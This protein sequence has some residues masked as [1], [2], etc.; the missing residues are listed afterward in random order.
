MR[1]LQECFRAL[2]QPGGR[3]R[4]VISCHIADQGGAVLAVSARSICQPY[5]HAREYDH[6]NTLITF[7]HK[8]DPERFERAA[9]RCI[10][11]DERLSPVTGTG[12]ENGE[13][14]HALTVHC[15]FSGHDLEHSVR[16]K[17]KAVTDALNQDGLIT[18]TTAETLYRELALLPRDPSTPETRSPHA[19]Y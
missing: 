11:E 2:Q 3:M 5:E 4:P 7:L 9:G 6:H 10:V 1:D 13:K 8:G 19:R 16:S 17:L 12:E 14:F 15:T 18:Q